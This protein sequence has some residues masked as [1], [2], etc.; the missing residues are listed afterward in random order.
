[1]L[2]RSPHLDNQYTV[3]GEVVEGMDVVDKIEKAQTDGNDRPVTDI[4]ILST[5]V[6]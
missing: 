5:K 4:R 3:F 2:F 6:L 1:M